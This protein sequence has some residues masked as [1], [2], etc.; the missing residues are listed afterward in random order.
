MATTMTASR[1]RQGVVFLLAWLVYMCLLA[2]GIVVTQLLGRTRRDQ[3]MKVRK[4]YAEQW[5]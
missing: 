5:H 4:P 2:L 1:P 3:V